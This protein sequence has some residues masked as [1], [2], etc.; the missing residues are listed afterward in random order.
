MTP[1]KDIVVR[2]G[3]EGVIRLCGLISFPLLAHALGADGYGVVIGTG[4]IIGL[5][6]AF[7]GLGLSFHVARMMQ[8]GDG[9]AN[10]RLLRTLLAINLL[11]GLI[12]AGMDLACAP[13]LARAFIPHPAGTMALMVSAGCMVCGTTDGVLLEWLR[14]RH[15]FV[16]IS[17]LQAGQALVQLAAILAVLACHGGVVA[18]VAVPACIQCAKFAVIWWLLRQAGEFATP[19]LLPR[20]QIGALVL[21]S[22]PVLSATLGTWLLSQGVRLAIGNRLDTAALGTFAAAALLATGIGMIGSAC[23]LPLYPRVARAVA[24]GQPLLVAR[25]CRGFGRF[26]HLAAIPALGLGSVLGGVAVRCL[27]GHAF[28]DVDLPCALLLAASYVEM[29]ALP[30]SY[31]VAAH[32]DAVRSRNGVLVGGATNLILAVALAPVAG[33]VGVAGAVLAGQLAVAAMNWRSARILGHRPGACLPWPSIA[34]ASVAA[35]AAMAAAFACRREGWTGLV[36]ASAAGAGVYL[37]VLALG[38]FRTM[39]R[40]AKTP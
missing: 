5:A 18:V 21:G 20:A 10:A 23:W 9:P 19:G 30:W 2:F 27:A 24:H 26:F 40:I 22:M 3:S 13:W 6:M 17:L 7:G 8:T 32:G 4:A 15:R 33:L 35:M 29:G 37:A 12:L 34:L 1:L 39:L 14:A 31:I 36:L 38:R 25:V 16:A 28:H 11:G